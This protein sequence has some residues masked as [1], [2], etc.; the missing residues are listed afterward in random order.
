MSLVMLDLV[1]I[2]RTSLLVLTSFDASR[3]FM[4]ILVWGT[5]VRS[6]CFMG[7]GTNYML[8]VDNHDVLYNITAT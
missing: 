4:Y 1:C 5:M 8:L 7:F 6:C 3:A 2:F